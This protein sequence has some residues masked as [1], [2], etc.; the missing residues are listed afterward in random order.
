VRVAGIIPAR[1]AS[2]RFAGKALATIRGKPLIRHV[3]D[4]AL[5]SPCLTEL[6]VATDDSR[7]VQAVEG[8]GGK[9]VL[10]SGRHRCGTERVAEVARSLKADVIV[11]IQGDE[12]FSDGSMIDECVSALRDSASVDSST[13]AAKIVEESELRSPNVVKVVTDLKGR[14]L[15]FS[16][17]SIPNT[18]CSSG[19][20]AEVNFLKHIG[21]YAFRRDFLLRFVEL[22]Q[23]PLE[24]AESLEQLRILEHGG[25]MAVAVTRHSS[26]G[27]DVP[28][29][30]EKATVF[31]AS[32][33][34]A[35]A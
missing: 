34:G 5:T 2:S 16:R 20:I 28:S 32:L 15:F 11:N 24:L 8:F 31:L 21:I 17:S 25:G 9:A 3:Y 6:L 10:T 23:T 1:F 12:L 4:R 30:V 14:A 27:V 13:L 33:E 22:E 29:D 19:R 18:E 35:D 7:I 26:V